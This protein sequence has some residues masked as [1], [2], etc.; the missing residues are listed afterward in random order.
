L[1]LILWG[2]IILIILRRQTVPLLVNT[3]LLRMDRIRN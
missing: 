2:T 1:L 3:Y